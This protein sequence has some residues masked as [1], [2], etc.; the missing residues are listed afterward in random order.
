[1]PRNGTG[2]YTLPYDWEDDDAADIPIRSDRMQGQ[3]DDIAT[4]LTNSLA[5]DGQTTPTAN[6]TMGGFRLTSLGA[7]TAA[8]DAVQAQQVQS[9][10]GV[11]VTA[12]GTDTYT[13]TPSPAITAYAA[14]QAF[15][16][17]FT[18]ANTGAATINLNSLGAK[19][20]V[21]NGSSAIGLGDIAAGMAS[22]I[23]YDGTNFQL[24]APSSSTLTNGGEVSGS[25]TP[26]ANG[27]LRINCTSAVATMQLNSMSPSPSDG[28]VI[29]FAKFGTNALTLS[30]TVNGDA[31][32]LVIVD[33]QTLK[34]T[35]TSRGW[36]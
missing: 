26:T 30:G 20:I 3:D 17:I 36:V 19:S 18:N 27:R 13:A 21:K 9:G 25:F 33:E 15:R 1:M 23:F 22:W 7:A 5:K 31:A 2:T 16:V 34:I 8:T 11:Y 28:D 14:G 4:A 29:E 12:S 32:G 6:L 35:R 10:A 24:I